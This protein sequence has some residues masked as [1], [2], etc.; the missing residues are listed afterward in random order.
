MA[1][2][3]KLGLTFAAAAIF[4]EVMLLKALMRRIDTFKYADRNKCHFI[5]TAT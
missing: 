3:T 2:G 1:Q 5:D 4:D